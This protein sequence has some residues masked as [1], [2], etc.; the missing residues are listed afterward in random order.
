MLHAITCMTKKS[1]DAIALFNGV[2]EDGT[3]LRVKK[4]YGLST[5]ENYNMM[6]DATRTAKLDGWFPIDSPEN[7]FEMAE[8][9]AMS[10]LRDVPFF[11]FDTNPTALKIIAE[12]N[13]FQSKTTAP[14]DANGNITSQNLFRGNRDGEL[15][16]PYISQF[17]LQDFDFGPNMPG[18]R[19]QTVGEPD[20]DNMLTKQRW[21]DVQRGFRID[22]PGVLRQTYKSTARTLGASVHNDP[23]YQFYQIAGAPPTRRLP[24]P[25][26]RLRS[27]P[28]RSSHLA[29]VLRG[30]THMA[31][32]H[33]P[34]LRAFAPSL[35]RHARPQRSW[36]SKSAFRRTNSCIMRPLP[37]QVAANP[38][39]L[40]QS[41]TLPS[42]RSEPLGG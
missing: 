23:F 3:A 14:T 34:L 26:R 15:V 16:G 21:L 6:G 1:L 9:W 37:G 2:K 20:P 5:G 13:K 41:R 33:A 22:A 24:S 35:P 17:A 25:E 8:V 10:L 39:C 7:A 40:P 31:C 4:L 36:P 30:C 12:L 32:S 11:E 28:L 29:A 19:Q 18:I 38:T 27:A 42:V